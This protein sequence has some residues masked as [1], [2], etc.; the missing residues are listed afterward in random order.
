M[1]ERIDADTQKKARRSA[2]LAALSAGSTVTAAAKSAGVGRTTVIRWMKDP[3]FVAELRDATTATI[4]AATSA[5][6][7]ATED[8]VRV[9]STIM[10]D[11][12]E[13]THARVSAARAILSAG[14]ESVARMN[15]EARLE[16][17][18]AGDGSGKDSVD[19]QLLRSELKRLQSM[20][21]RQNGAEN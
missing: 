10:V 2:V 14:L 5:V 1:N 7:G 6:V 9:L 17:L 21:T 20:G 15:L 12:A 19:V 8:A 16:S 4:A 3:D 18:E 13:P 11:P